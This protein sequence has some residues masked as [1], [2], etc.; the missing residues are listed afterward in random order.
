MNLYLAKIVYKIVKPNTV[1][2]DQYDE[3]L[4]FVK[5]RD[6]HEAFFKARMLGVKN[7]DEVAQEGG[8]SILWKFVDVP[9]LK[10]INEI[11]DG[12]ELHSAIIER[13]SEDAYERFIKARASELQSAIEQQSPLF[14]S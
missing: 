7:E 8:S 1:G 10:E 6:N 5:A 14:I 9:F 4:C 13:D 3:Q 2:L 12:V 11:E